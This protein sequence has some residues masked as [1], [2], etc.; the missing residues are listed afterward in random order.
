M[1]RQKR[2]PRRSSGVRSAR[3]APSCWE[4]LWTAD[5]LPEVPGGPVDSVRQG[6][7]EP[8][9]EA[10]WTRA[11]RCSVTLWT[12]C[13]RS[14]WHRWRAR[15]RPPIPVAGDPPRG[16]RRGASVAASVPL[17][18][19]LGTRSGKAGVLLPSPDETENLGRQINSSTGGR[20]VGRPWKASWRSPHRSFVRRMTR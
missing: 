16:G 3:W 1:N 10:C 12:R 6:R 11:R 14:R 19:S 4:Q 17:S 15:N 7:S 13:R 5:G 20:E 9:R 18:Q 2:R 8:P